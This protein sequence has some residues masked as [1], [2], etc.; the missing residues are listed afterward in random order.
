MSIS[1]PL[2]NKKSKHSRVLFLLKPCNHKPTFTAESLKSIWLTVYVKSVM[3]LQ[4]NILSLFAT[5]PIFYLFWWNFKLLSNWG[6][7]FFDWHGYLGCIGKTAT[8]DNSA[9]CQMA[10]SLLLH[11]WKGDSLL[12][13]PTWWKTDIQSVCNAHI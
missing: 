6:R 12:S 3:G 7:Y 8:L 9:P 4:W 5:F 10:F 1:L 11:A 13:G 2:E